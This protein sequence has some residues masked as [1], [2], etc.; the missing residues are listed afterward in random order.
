MCHF[1]YVAFVVCIYFPIL[2]NLHLV[3]KDDNI[4][5]KRSTNKCGCTL[6]DKKWVDI[7]CQKILMSVKFSV[8]QNPVNATECTIMRF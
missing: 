3:N 5:E 7:Y 1:I 4:N 6:T 8:A 2:S